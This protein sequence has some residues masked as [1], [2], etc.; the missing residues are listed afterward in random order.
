[1]AAERQELDRTLAMLA[2]LLGVCGLGLL[3]ITSAIVPRVLR[4]ELAPLDALAEH[5]TRIDATTLGRRFVTEHLQSELAPIAL[6][7]ND[8]LS[9]LERSFD[10][11]KQFSADVAHELRTPIAELRS[12]A[13]LALKWPESRDARA[14]ADALQIAMTMEGIVTGLLQLLRNEAGREVAYERV[15]LQ[16][17]LQAARVV[18]EPRIASR[19]L[20]VTWSVADD[21]VVQANP[22]LLRSLVS[23]LLDNAVEYTPPGGAVQVDALQETAGV[24]LRVANDVEG[25]TEDDLERL[26]D[27]FWRR[28]QVRSSAGHYGLGLS[29]ARASAQALGCELIASLPTPSRIALTL[30]GLRQVAA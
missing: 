20:Q 18:L 4:R 24:V 28:D 16:A 21:I 19:H 7:F 6:R 3:A 12:M 11:E 23:N 9:R 14:D 22:E 30:S 17:L 8:L 10:R 5:A 26:F 25:L 15:P 2:V 13:E 1:V 29:I 27:R